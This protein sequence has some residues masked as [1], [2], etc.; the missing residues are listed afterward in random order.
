MKTVLSIQSHVAYGYVGNRAAVFPLQRLGIDAIAVN[1]VQFSNHT[2]YG[3]WTGQVFTAEHIADVVD[4]I[5]ARGVLPQCDAVL[6]GYMGDVGLGQVI[7]ETAARVKAANPQAIYCCD[8]VMGDVGRG[9]FV[10]PGLPDFIKAHAVPAA[11]L[12]TPNQFEL[13]YLADRPVGTLDDALAATAALRSRG[14]R[15]ILVTSL[16]RSDVPSDTIEMLVDDADGAWLVATPR[17]DLTPSP[18]GSGDAVAALFL[19]HYLASRDPGEA[20]GQAAAAIFAIFEA[21][22]TAGTRELQIVGA[23][24]AFVRPERRFPVTR[25][26]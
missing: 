19:A 16:T 3:A 4:G 9:F 14:P 8:P 10:R 22:R 18:N 20:L 13:E 25:L 11:D 17:L 23:Q 15:L 24:D 5:A 12:M 26:R 7:V 2:G 21:T 1:T 6:S